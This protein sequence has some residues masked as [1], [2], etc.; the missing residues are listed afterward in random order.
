MA[1]EKGR[2][3][4]DLRKSRGPGKRRKPLADPPPVFAAEIVPDSDVRRCGDI[5][6]SVRILHGALGLIT[7]PKMGPETERELKARRDLNDAVRRMLILGLVLST[8]CIF[9]GLGLSTISHCPLPSKVSG[10]RQILDGLKRASPQSFLDLGI[11]LLIAT[12][13][14]RVLGSLVEFAEKRDWRY[15]FVASVVLIILAISV[16]VGTR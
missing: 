16:A 12:P 15:V 14:L 4:A 3:V 8:V 5:P 2:P 7:T 11:L 13:V 6:E 1:E 10:L 9:A